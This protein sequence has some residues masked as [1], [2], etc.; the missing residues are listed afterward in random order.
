MYTF[1]PTPPKSEST[2]DLDTNSGADKS[3]M[4]LPKQLPSSN[5]APHSDDKE[6][7]LLSL[8][9]LQHQKSSYAPLDGTQ[10]S[11]FSP[12]LQGDLVS[13]R[14]SRLPITTSLNADPRTLS[15]HL[16]LRVK[17]IIACSESMWEWVE[18][19]QLEAAT[20]PNL[21][22]LNNWPLD[23]ARCAILEMTRED[24][25]LLLNNFTLQVP[26]SS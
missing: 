3:S 15:L 24:F 26:V 5:G 7:S 20:I 8:Q 9:S 22:N 2:D 12:P 25:D 23:M 6:H 17:E 13:K 16:A 1:P 18:Q 14:V 19:F 11:T 21:N 10:G 4:I